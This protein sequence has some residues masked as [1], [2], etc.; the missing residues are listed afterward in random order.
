MRNFS[1]QIKHFVWHVLQGFLT[2][3]FSIDP[4]I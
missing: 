3:E 1:L 4:F 2:E